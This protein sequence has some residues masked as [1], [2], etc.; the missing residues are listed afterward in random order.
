[1]RFGG[2][3]G[4]IC[5][6][7]LTE[8]SDKKLFLL[9]AYALIFRAYYAFIRNPRINSKGENTS[10]AFGFTTAVLDILRNEK[11]THIAI[12]FD[13]PGPTF[14]HEEYPEYKANRD[15]T[16]EDIRASVP[17][18]HKVAE[19][20]RIPTITIPG[21]EADDT[22]GCLAVMAEKEGFDV[23]MMTPD[24]DYA[25]LVTEKV[26]MYRPGRSGNPPQVWGPAEVC[27]RFGIDNP[28]QVIDLLGLM[29]DSA[30]NIPGV[31]GIGPKTAAKL[32][33]TYGS[34]ETLLDSTADLK[35]KQKENLENFRAQALLSK[36]LATIALDVPVTPD[37]DAMRIDG[38]DAEKLSE[39]FEALEFRTLA[40]R[41]L[42]ASA[43]PQANVAAADHPSEAAKT[44]TD[45]GQSQMDMFGVSTDAAQDQMEPGLTSFDAE[46]V[47]YRMADSPEGWAQVCAEIGAVDRFAFD[48]ETTGLD[49]RTA[50]LVGMSFSTAKGTGWYVPVPFGKQG[51]HQ[52]H[53]PAVQEILKAFGAVWSAKEKV[54]IAQNWKFDYKV[55][56]TAGVEIQCRVFDT[57]LA[58]YVLQ[59]DL[60]HGMDYLAEVELGYKTIPIA[61]ILGKRGKNQKTMADIPSEQV[62]DYACED[63]DITLQLADVFEGRM[64][65]GSA[66]RQV[67]DTL[68]MP[69]VPVLAEMEMEGV[70]LDV[71]ALNGMA[72]GLEEDLR[73]L[74]ESIQAHAGVP[75]SIDS[76]RQLGEVLFDHLVITEKAKKT[77]TGQYATGED[78]LQ[79]LVNAHPIVSEVL[80]YRQL[81]KLLSTYVRPLPEL[82]EEKTQ[83]IHTQYMQAVAAT[84][85]LSSTQPN[86]QNIPIRTLRGREIRKAFVPRDD[87]HVLLAADYSQVE[88]RIV[89]ALSGD[90]GLCQAFLDGADIHTATAA[91]VFGIS[92]DEVDRGQRSQAKAVNFGILYGQGAFGLAETLKI[93]RREAKSIIEAYFTEF[94]DLKAYQTQVV[95]TAKEKG[96]VET[97]L[98]RKRWL[99]DITSANAVVRGFAERNAVN[100]PIQGSAADIIKVAMVRI[101]KAI[102]AEEL[103]ARM[104]LQVHDELVFDVP[105]T[106][107]E[108][109]SKLVK[110]HMEEAVKLSVPLEVEIQTGTNWLEAH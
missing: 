7:M 95:E 11:P 40:R 46:K 96:Y 52:S 62:R 88:L 32:L 81:N 24:K 6:P 53:D 13:P 56:R 61:D 39:V 49:A 107:A 22:I 98:G 74:T 2:G 82:V 100:A 66:E 54:L 41:A 64:P 1:V 44:A 29:G 80:E 65:K 60:K 63:A 5:P 4:L 86:L 47:N 31:P 58:H 69:L 83:R 42:G 28:L 92:P 75:F 48:T 16:P 37:F 38:P 8:E 27:E 70:R 93:P 19:S 85:R 79:K 34:M 106:E 99:P 21:F 72:K 71:E 25:Q 15:E 89:A 10:A 17:W 94:P 36:H 26:R 102:R 55:M 76:P 18:I 12:V 23:Y 35:G 103:D 43:P 91:K 77:K 78:I 108:A 9:D 59:P 45:S 84:G 51:E 3:L 67:L 57:M 73:R 110:T 104:I 20:L 90:R 14:R 50:R 68:E 109:L 101:Q 105:K 87:N 33:N 97:V 30:D